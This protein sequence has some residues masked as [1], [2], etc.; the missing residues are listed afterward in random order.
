VV[1]S[2][3]GVRLSFSAQVLTEVHASDDRAGFSVILLAFSVYIVYLLEIVKLA[4]P[5]IRR[6]VAERATDDA[7]RKSA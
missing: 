1:D 2:A 4:N 3:T 7:R 6:R 5:R